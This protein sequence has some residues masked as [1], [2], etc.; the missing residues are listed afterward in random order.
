M[1]FHNYLS[2]GK[3]QNSAVLNDHMERFILFLMK[4]HILKEDGVIMCTSDGAPSRYRCATAY[5][6]CQP[7]LINTIL[8]LTGL[9]ELLV[10]VK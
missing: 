6:F 3:Q 8:Q 2:D 10:M 1:E 5:Y 9:Y 7:L 4:E